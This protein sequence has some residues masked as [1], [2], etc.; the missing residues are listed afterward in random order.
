MINDILTELHSTLT[1]GHLGRNKTL[2]KVKQRFYWTGWRDDVIKFCEQCNEC[3]QKK[4][5]PKKPRAQ[6]RQYLV[7]EPLERVGLDILGPLPKTNSGNKYIL[8]LVDYFS[9]WSEAFPMRNQEASTIANKLVSGF[10]NIFGIPKTIHTDQGRQFESRLF[11]ELCKLLGIHKSRTTPFRPQSNGLVEKYNKTLTTMLSAFV[12][13]NQ[14]DWDKY[15]SVLNMAYRATPQESTNVTPNMLMLGRE[16]NL[17][18]D[19]MIGSPE[20][21][22]LDEVEYVEVLRK[23]MENAYEYARAHLKQAASRQKQYY[24]IKCHGKSFVQG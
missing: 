21:E 17:S 12:D 5:A 19:I 18:I 11:K 20:N 9:K 24:D 10:I 13:E 3:A 2:G 4:S 14:R 1:S 23:R 15:V 16:V 8:V 7:G 6:L 22:I